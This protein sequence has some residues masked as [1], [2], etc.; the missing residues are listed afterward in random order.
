MLNFSYVFISL[1]G[2]TVRW[3]DCEMGLDDQGVVRYHT[4]RT[5]NSQGPRHK[6]RNGGAPFCCNF[7]HPRQTTLAWAIH[8]HGP[9]G[10]LS[11]KE[12]CKRSTDLG[13]SGCNWSK[14]PRGKK[15]L[16]CFFLMLNLRILTKH[17]TWAQAPFECVH[18]PVLFPKE[19]QSL[20]SY[21][22]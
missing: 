13:S 16:I 6:W 2:Q 4:D 1:N 8:I 18:S 5:E 15:W 17:S 11:R 9:K 7:L 22:L 3:S 20:W 14:N 21:A 10:S 19:L 12:A